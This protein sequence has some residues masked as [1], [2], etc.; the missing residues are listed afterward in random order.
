M[1][2]DATFRFVAEDEPAEGWRAVVAHG[3][4]GWRAWFRARGDRRAPGVVACRMALA[5]YMPSMGPLVG[6]LVEAAGGD[7]EMTRFL[8]FWSPPRYLVNCT[9]LATCDSDGPL[10]IRNYDLDPR[11][12][13]TTMLRSRWLGRGVVG[14]VEGLAGLSDGMNDRGLAISLT[15]GGRVVR[16]PGFGIPLII[17]YLLESC[18]TVR[19]AVDELRRIPCH[20]SYNVTLADASGDVATVML[21]PERPAMVSGAPWAANHQLG[22]EWPQHGRMTRTLERSE[23][24]DRLLARGPV[25]AA[26]LERIFLS[27]PVYSGRYAD[28][29]GTVFTT[30][31]RPVARTV[32]IGWLEGPTQAWDFESPPPGADPGPL[33]RGVVQGIPA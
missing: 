30:F 28:G 2:M 16:G 14:M 9:Q 23:R 3:W 15:F 27:E 6:A 8:S 32:R 29:F 1:T 7:E 13:E 24:L 22:V 17:R 5:K 20:M 12:N 19:D 31:Y 21:S 26:T 33:S 4:P 25:D 18:Q 11:L 10:L